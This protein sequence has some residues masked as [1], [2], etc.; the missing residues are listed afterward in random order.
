MT[1]NVT[2]LAQNSDINYVNQA[3]ACAMSIKHTTPDSKICIITNDVIDERFKQVF[4]YVIP[5][6]WGDMADGV[7][8][9]IQ[10]RWKIYHV[11]PF[12]ET[13]VL[14]TDMLVLE[15]LNPLWES[16]RKY[17]VFYTTEV[18][19]YR[20]YT[21]TNDYYRKTFTKNS[22]KNIY[23]GLHYFK[24]NEWSKEFYETLEIVVKN[25]KTFYSKFAKGIDSQKFLSMDLCVAITIKILESEKV[26]TDLTKTPRFV[27]MKSKVQGWNSNTSENW[28]LNINSYLTENLEL[29]VGNYKQRGIF[30]YTVDEFL[31]HDIIKTYEKKLGLL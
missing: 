23:S 27:H 10:N 30:H 1:V 5:I 25:W 9:K 19:D 26:V 29:Y 3:Y 4:D 11:V 14:D 15:N 24:K 17:N 31:T 20:N 18:T 12:E 2:F 21:I 28:M 22:L 7:S 13:I 8:W 6:P 16:L